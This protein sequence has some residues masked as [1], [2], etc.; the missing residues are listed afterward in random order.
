VAYTFET[1]G[2]YLAGYLLDRHLTDDGRSWT[3]VG[4]TLLRCGQSADWLQAMREM[5]VLHLLHRLIMAGTVIARRYREQAI[6]VERET[7]Q[8]ILEHM[9]VGWED[10]SALFARLEP[11]IRAASSSVPEGVRASLTEAARTSHAVCY[12]CGT[13]LEFIERGFRSFTLD[14]VWPQAFGGDSVEENLLPACRSCNECKANVAAWSLYPIQAMVHGFQM[15]DEDLSF[16]S[17]EMRLAVHARA[18]RE[19]ARSADISLRDSYLHLG[20]QGVPT[21]RNE[22]LAVDVFN[23]AF[24]AL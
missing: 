17:K 11:A 14:H 6:L 15:T 12:M 5:T 20:P 4:M 10:V 24:S 3:S 1:S 19:H 2:E 21:P 18:V 22:S 9:V 8:A 13:Q 23:L 16:L 7:K